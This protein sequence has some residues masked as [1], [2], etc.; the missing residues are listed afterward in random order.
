MKLKIQAHGA[1]A[2]RSTA[3][4][5][6]KKSPVP[7]FKGFRTAAALVVVVVTAACSTVP[8]SEF[9][10]FVAQ[11]PN[12]R[13]MNRVQITWETRP[14]AAQY[15]SKILTQLGSAPSA[16]PIACATWSAQN[17][18]CTIITTP[19]PNHVVIGHEVRH[20]FEGNFH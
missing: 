2:R 9:E 12:K 13:I 6:G 17:S 20:C 5:A 3:K 19:N 8:A 11:A 7:F 1:V 15:C 16:A 4:T 18:I 14:D 10:T